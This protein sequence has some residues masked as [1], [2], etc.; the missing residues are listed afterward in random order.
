VLGLSIFRIHLDILFV[1]TRVSC[2]KFRRTS[3][4]ECKLFV[5]GSRIMCGV[6]EVLSASPVIWVSFVR[7]VFRICTVWHEGKNVWL[8]HPS[9]PTLWEALKELRYVNYCYETVWLQCFFKWFMW[10]LCTTPFI[11]QTV[12]FLVLI[13]FLCVSCLITWTVICVL[14]LQNFKIKYFIWQNSLHQT[15]LNMFSLSFYISI[16]YA[17]SLKLWWQ[18]CVDALTHM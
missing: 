7:D 14:L 5:G 15:L 3:L 9:G 11:L 17:I 4:C 13:F 2:F 1:E 8:S 10:L 12:P 6:M 16:S 18:Y